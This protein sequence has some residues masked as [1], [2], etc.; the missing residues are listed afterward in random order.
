MYFANK[1]RKYFSI[2][3]SSLLSNIF[4][5]FICLNGFFHRPFS[6]L[7]IFAWCL[8]ILSWLL[9]LYKQA[10][11]CIHICICIKHQASHTISPSNLWAKYS[12]CHELDVLNGRFFL[13][14]V[15]AVVLTCSYLEPFDNLRIEYSKL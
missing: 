8:C 2:F 1:L 7:A 6:F 5:T 13:V 11:C 3:F 15:M 9:S 12:K 14:S 10:R 4:N